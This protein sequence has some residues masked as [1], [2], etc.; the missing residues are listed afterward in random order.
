MPWSKG[1]MKIKYICK[2]IFYTVVKEVFIK[3]I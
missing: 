3:I 2:I 1:M